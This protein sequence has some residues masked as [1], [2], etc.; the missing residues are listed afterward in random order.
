MLFMTEAW[1][2]SLSFSWA[3]CLPLRRRRGPPQKENLRRPAGGRRDPESQI[4]AGAHR[5][6]HPQVQAGEGEVEAQLKL[7]SFFSWFRKLI[8]FIEILC[9]TSL[10]LNLCIFLSDNTFLFVHIF[11]LNMM[12]KNLVSLNLLTSLPSLLIESSAFFPL[13]T[14]YHK[15]CFFMIQWPCSQSWLHNHILYSVNHRYTHQWRV[16]PLIGS[17]T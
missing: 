2:F 6:A 12:P 5:G 11:S 1:H 13:V 17:N 8:S 14:K 15:V 4:Q 10:V 9:S 16:P 7:V 3:D